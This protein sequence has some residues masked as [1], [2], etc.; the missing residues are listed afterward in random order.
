MIPLVLAVNP[1]LAAW[2]Q[3]AA[4][5]IGIFVFVFAIIAL[6]FNLAMSFGLAWVREKTEAVK[7]LRPTVESINKTTASALQG[8]PPSA[9][10]NTIV[11]TVANIPARVQ[12]IDKQVDRTTER[13]ANAVIE[14]RARTVQAQTVL[15]AFFLPGLTRQPRALPAKKDLQLKSPDYHLLVEEK[16]SKV[17]VESISNGHSRDT[18]AVTS[19]QLKNVSAY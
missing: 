17:P 5:V 14:F 18:E 16:P 11:R 6:A 4:I 3:I 15:K 2:G 1:I 7:M 19:G 8:V 10:E 12:A 13:A 9:N